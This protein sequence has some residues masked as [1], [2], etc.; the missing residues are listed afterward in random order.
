M[1]WRELLAALQIEIQQ[2]TLS[3][4]HDEPGS[5]G[6]VVT[7]CPQCRKKFQTTWQFV[8][9]IAHDVLPCVIAK[10]STRIQFL[11]GLRA[12]RLHPTSGTGLEILDKRY[13]FIF[14]P[15]GEYRGKEMALKRS[16]RWQQ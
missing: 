4:F 16:E 13:Q 12:T 9:R 15:S 3:T 6:V 14:S 11:S 7:G 8:E 1:T 5:M 10:V 2:H